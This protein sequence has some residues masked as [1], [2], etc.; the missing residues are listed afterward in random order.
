MIVD[1]LQTPYYAVIFST[2]LSDNLE[3][4]EEMANKMEDLAKKQPGYLGV[5][6]ARNQ[7]GI[8]VSYWESIDDIVQWKNN[9]EHTKARNLGRAQWYKK[10]QLRICKI[11]REYGFEN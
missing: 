11:E 4:Y 1:N 8:T 7:I 5:E 9:I 3:G 10:Y 2:L 6:S